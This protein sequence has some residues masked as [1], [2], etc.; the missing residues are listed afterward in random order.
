MSG[1]NFGGVANFTAPTHTTVVVGSSST[2][3]L[4]KNQ[5]RKYVVLQNV[6][7]EPISIKFGAAAVIG[8]GIMLS[9]DSVGGAAPYGDG[10]T[11]EISPSFGNLVWGT[12]N[13]ISAS[14]S[15]NLLVTECE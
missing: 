15:M 8:A 2:A 6:S 14:G 1:N 12:V 11:F 5:K 7:I 4:I 9:A 3:V 10:G 13:A